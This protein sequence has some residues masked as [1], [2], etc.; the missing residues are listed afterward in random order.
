MLSRLNPRERLVV[1][2]RFGLGEEDPLTLE[3]VGNRLKRSRERIRQTEERAKQK[4]RMMAKSRHLT[5]Y[6]N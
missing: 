6:L 1:E 2:L 4:L 5:Y 3:E